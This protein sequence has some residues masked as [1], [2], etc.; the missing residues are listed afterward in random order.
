MPALFLGV[1]SW[2]G[3]TETHNFHKQLNNLRLGR[4][5]QVI[6]ILSTRCLQNQT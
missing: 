1:T 5:P 6:T 2:S 4:I 3:D